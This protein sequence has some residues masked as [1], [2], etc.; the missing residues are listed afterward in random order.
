MA[1]TIVL[2]YNKSTGGDEELFNKTAEDWAKAIEKTKKS[3]LRNFY[4]K[5]LE[6]ET[7]SKHEEWT[8][9]LPFVKMLNS[10]VAYGVSRSVVSREFQDMMTQ[11]I[12]K[13]NTKEDLKVFKLFFEAVLGFFKGRD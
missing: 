13:V 11:C 5:V 7:H 12:S 6:L 1:N 10:K 3:Q 8:N 2:N 9:V 4:D